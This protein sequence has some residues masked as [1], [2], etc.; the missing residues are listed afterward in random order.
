M[1]YSTAPSPVETRLRIAA[2]EMEIDR[3]L[4][5]RTEA[6]PESYLLIDYRI[7]QI[8]GDIARLRRGES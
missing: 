5:A 2:R 6:G 4:A 3:L 7:A 8:E 1:L